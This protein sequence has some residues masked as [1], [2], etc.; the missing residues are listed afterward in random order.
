MGLPAVGTKTS[1]SAYINDASLS[2]AVSLERK[3]RTLQKGGGGKSTSNYGPARKNKNKKQ[4]RR[5]SGA[6][7]LGTAWY[8]GPAQSSRG[9]PHQTLYT[10]N[11]SLLHVALFLMSENCHKGEAVHGEGQIRQNIFCDS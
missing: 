10:L 4:A 7:R 8:V 2:V 5:D 9:T 3:N 11:P 6:R 1:F